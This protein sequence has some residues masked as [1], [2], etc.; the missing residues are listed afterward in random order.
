MCIGW[1]SF[2]IMYWVMFISS[3]IGCMLLWC[4]CL[5]I[6]SGVVVC[7]LMFLMMWLMKCGVLVLV[8]SVMVSLWLFMVVIGVVLNGIILLVYVVV[9][10]K[11]MLWMLK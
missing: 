7:G 9:M 2:S 3:D 8:C 5:V 10:L 6:Y 11:V 4:R 1:F